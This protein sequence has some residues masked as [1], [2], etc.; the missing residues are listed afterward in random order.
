MGDMPSEID[1]SPAPPGPKMASKLSGSSTL[2]TCTQSKLMMLQQT[3]APKAARNFA[4]NRAAT[5]GWLRL[6]LKSQGVD[7]YFCDCM[8]PAMH[9]PASRADLFYLRMLH[10]YP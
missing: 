9:Q 2:S 10:S 3:L 1:D 7:Q 4:F 8:V 5:M 6:P